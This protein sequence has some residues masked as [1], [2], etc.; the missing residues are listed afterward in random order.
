MLTMD[1]EDRV[2]GW[3]WAGVKQGNHTVQESECWLWE[4]SRLGSAGDQDD[5]SFGNRLARGLATGWQHVDY[6]AWLL[7]LLLLLH[8]GS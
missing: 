8:I 1:K 2:V 7:L 3:P 5:S 6:Q 4:G